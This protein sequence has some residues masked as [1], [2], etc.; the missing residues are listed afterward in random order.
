[1]AKIDE[2][3]LELCPDGVEWKTIQNSI[4]SLTT[5]VNPRKHFVL[6]NE[7]SCFYY[8][9]GKNLSSNKIN[10][11][12]STDK[13]DANALALI[14]KRAKLSDNILLFS[15]AGTV[16][17]IAYVESYSND[18][19]ISEMVFAIK[20]DTTQLLPKYLM[21]MLNTWYGKNQYMRKVYT[22]VL[23]YIKTSDLLNVI[24]PLPSIQIQQKIVDVLDTFT[25][26][27]SNLEEEL[28]LRE[29]QC[30][31]YR[32]QLFNFDDET[33][34]GKQLYSY[35]ID[36]QTLSEVAEIGTGISNTKDGL[37]QGL[38]PFYTRGQDIL[39][40]NEYEF[41][42]EA[43]I[44]A[45]DGVGVGKT[46]HYVKGKYALHQRAYRFSPKKTLLGKFLFYYMKVSF[47]KYVCGQ[48]VSSSVSSLRKPKLMAYPIPILPIEKQQ[49]IVEILDTFEA[50]IA[51]IKEE[52]ALR[53][54]Q[55]EYY[56]EK[57]LSFGK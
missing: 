38:F 51:N 24:I 2:L 13:V 3:L 48:S 26:A 19:T 17:K 44:T 22:G 35:L 1:M 42:E 30:E 20:T 46:I 28:A 25:D 55:Y 37:S 36:W 21:Y 15:C 16:G 11:D 5:G 23:N 56:R 45:G 18:W 29:K 47:Y 31:Y 7:D 53:T 52:I 10:I 32:E 8:I 49:E 14:N 27:I 57:L 33:S 41:D 6:N 34:L 40:K 4:V 54:K 9:T 12:Q 43:V 39:W 50:M